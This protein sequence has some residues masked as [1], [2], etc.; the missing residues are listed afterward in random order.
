[1][2]FRL[3]ILK[4]S[5]GFL[6]TRWG[7]TV[8][9]STNLTL[10]ERT[11]GRAFNSRSGNLHTIHLFLYEPKVANIELKTRLKPLLGSLP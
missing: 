4:W 2:T 9:A 10:A 11:L 5:K 7:E 1:V 8:W 6:N 3:K